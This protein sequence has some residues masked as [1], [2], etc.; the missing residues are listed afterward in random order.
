MKI[1][2]RVL[3][4]LAAE[5][6][7]A[8]L[9][10]E[11]DCRLIFPGLTES[12]AIELHEEL[13]RRLAAGVDGSASGIPVYL[14]LDYPA[15]HFRPDKSKGWLHYEAVTS[16]R[17][18]SFVTVC[19]P[20]VLPKLHDSIRG[21]G[22]PIRGM[23][24]ADEWPW[25]D[26]GVEAFRFNGPV[27]DA[28]LD[29][30]TVDT[31]SR[32]WMRELIL[33]GV[34]TAAAPLRDKIR[35]PLLLEEILG[36]FES[37]LYA[38]L[39][40]VVDKFCFHC[41]IPRVVSRD[42]VTSAEYVDAVELT[43]KAFDEQRTKNPEFRDYLVNEVAVSTF[44]A[45]DSDSLQQLTTSLDLLLDGALELGADSG[46][47]A[48]RGGLGNGSTSATIEAWSALDLDRLRKLF[49]VGEQ[50]IVQCTA[51]ILDGNGVVSTDG[52]HVVI[53]EDV[54]LA[55]NVR[56]KIGSDRFTSGDFQIRCKRRQRTLYKKECVEAEF[57]STVTIP[58]N[59]LPGTQS[60][61]SLVVQ[62]VRF[63]QVVSEARVY[64]H[65]CGTVRPAMVVFEPSFD[66]FDLLESQPDSADSESVKLSCREPV[67]LHVFDCQ[68]TDLCSVTAD[69]EALTLG[70]V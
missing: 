13:Q 33:E 52:K 58:A 53:F 8:V 26:D 28:M 15:S 32:Q 54:P 16:V 65:V 63:Q 11:R 44:A 24:F 21:T 10:D 37:T 6:V 57:K 14:A 9:S 55:L 27:L 31:E 3:S 48:Y 29:L 60:R 39:D 61:L 64:V 42:R 66:V 62:L 59:E 56:V 45:L 12:L 4:N 69:D 67:R 43:A 40:D 51:S 7:A 68:G 41:G 1:L 20:K 46:L 19:M 34:V 18:G 23:T 47:L 35:V 25:K 22:S 5:H 50:D 36:S 70:K 2:S 49:G 17:Q 38:E 30:W